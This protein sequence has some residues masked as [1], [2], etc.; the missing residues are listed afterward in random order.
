MEGIHL[1]NLD[2]GGRLILTWI[3]TKYDDGWDG[4]DWTRVTRDR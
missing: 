4:V 2:G 1:E 3:L